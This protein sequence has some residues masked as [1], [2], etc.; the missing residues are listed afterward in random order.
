MLLF[1]NK[2]ALFQMG[3]IG[4][5]KIWRLFSLRKTEMEETKES[6]IFSPTNLC[7]KNARTFE[8]YESFKWKLQYVIMYNLHLQ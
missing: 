5:E 3:L 2:S 6:N 8:H 4:S 1:Q 7:G